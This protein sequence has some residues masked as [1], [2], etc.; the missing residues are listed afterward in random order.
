VPL[1]DVVGIK[2]IDLDYLRL[3]GTFFG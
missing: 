2:Q 3:A 1:G